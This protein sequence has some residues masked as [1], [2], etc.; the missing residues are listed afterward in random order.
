MFVTS[1]EKFT[2]LTSAFKWVKICANIPSYSN[3]RCDL[4]PTQSIQN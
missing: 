4:Y 1:N 2:Q 3:C